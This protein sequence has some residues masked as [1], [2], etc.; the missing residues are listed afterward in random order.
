VGYEGY[1]VHLLNLA[2][3]SV[4][5]APRTLQTGH[6]PIYT[7]NNQTGTSKDTEI[8]DSPLKSNKG[9]TQLLHSENS[10]FH[11]HLWKKALESAALKAP[12]QVWGVETGAIRTTAQK[13]T[14]RSD[15][16]VFTSTWRQLWGVQQISDGRYLYGTCQSICEKRL[17]RLSSQIQAQTSLIAQEISPQS[18][19][20]LWSRLW[21]QCEVELVYFKGALK[22]KWNRVH[23][24]LDLL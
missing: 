15:F 7:Q 3:N 18:K 19:R 17:S 20:T 21:S 10:S 1:P 5:K 2:H 8:T 23:W 12:N 16:N 6:V 11:S 22:K 24:S 14:T 13:H 9:S 4:D